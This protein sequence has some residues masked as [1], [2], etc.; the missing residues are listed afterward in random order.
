MQLEAAHRRKPASAK[1]ASVR[2]RG[3]KASL[4]S[5]CVLCAASQAPLP[6]APCAPTREA[7]A[8]HGPPFR[9]GPLAGGR[10]SK[11]APTR[12][13]GRSAPR[14]E[15]AEQ[16]RPPE[17]PSRHTRATTV[18]A[19]GRAQCGSP[20]GLSSLGRARPGSNFQRRHRFAPQRRSQTLAIRGRTQAWME[21]PLGDLRYLASRSRTHLG[22]CEGV[23]RRLRGGQVPRDPARGRQVG[24]ERG[25]ALA[26]AVVAAYGPEGSSEAH[27]LF[28]A[29]LRHR[30]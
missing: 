20:S 16:F 8:A 28:G 5:R 9:Q 4:A 2:Q 12:S 24:I 15:H 25:V 22:G 18:H 11:P 1:I 26:I 21:H 23:R 19:Q 3:C 6:V 14:Q 17:L 29:T 13:R 7:G 30:L 10:R 27:G